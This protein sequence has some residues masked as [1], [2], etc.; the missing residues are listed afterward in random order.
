MGGIF[1]DLQKLNTQPETPKPTQSE[2]AD[3]PRPVKPKQPPVRQ[4]AGSTNTHVIT[5]DRFFRKDRA[6]S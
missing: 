3:R 4:D 2:A 5:N 1:G 6:I